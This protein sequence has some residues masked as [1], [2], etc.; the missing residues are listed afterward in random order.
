MALVDRVKN[1]LLSPRAEWQV[2]D[3]EPATVSSLYAGYIAPLSA[4][5]AICQAVGMALI[6]ISIPFVG[7]S[8]KTPFGSAITN[9][10]VTYVLGLVAV[11]IVALIVDALAPS[12]G[13]TK[14]QIQ[15]LKVVAYAYTAAWVG[16]IFSLIPA[17]GI[18]AVIFALYSL[19]LLYLGLPVLMK[20]PADKALGYTVVVVLVTMVVM[21]VIFY[22]V[23]MLG[24]GYGMGAM[25]G[26]SPYRP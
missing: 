17:L 9:A 26:G 18:I 16:G 25:G 5:P 14:N 22:I 4:I 20:A 15:A 1:I 3:A 12:F 13:G 19:Y 24:F 7:G 23:R 10:A 8:Y 11:Y 2:I 6:G 21:F